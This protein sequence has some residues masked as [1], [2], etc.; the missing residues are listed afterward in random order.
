L[1]IHSIGFIR[2]A[3]KGAR[4]KRKKDWKKTA[5]NKK[6]ENKKEQKGLTW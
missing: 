3:L 4:E 6:Q 5:E 2:G 1:L